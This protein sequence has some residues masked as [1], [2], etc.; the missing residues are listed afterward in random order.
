LPYFLLPLAI[1]A[2]VIGLITPMWG[3]YL[4]MFPLGIS[5]GFISTLLD[6]LWPEVYGPANLGGI[7]AIVSSAMVFSTAIGSGLSGALIDRG[8]SLPKQMLC[9]SGWCI[10]ACFVLA[11][12]AS[13]IGLRER[14]R[15]ARKVHRSERTR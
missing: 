14:G 1:A 9:L 4:F 3:V 8:I 5:N 2:T 15:A 10:A 7:R 11:F 12:A 13:R 6:A